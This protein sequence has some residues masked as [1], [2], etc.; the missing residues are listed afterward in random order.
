MSCESKAGTGN[1][2]RREEV[3][4]FGSSLESEKTASSEQ[5]QQGNP[6]AS[7]LAEEF[8]YF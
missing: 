8:P 7:G 2:D 6:S 4:L 5:K 3:S 1:G